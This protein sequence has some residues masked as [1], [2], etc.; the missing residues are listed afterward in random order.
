MRKE[1]AYQII[2]Q[3][4]LIIGKESRTILNAIIENNINSL[5]LPNGINLA[6]INNLALLYKNKLAELSSSHP[7][8]RYLPF[9]HIIKD[10]IPSFDWHLH[11]NSPRINNLRP[12]LLS[13]LLGKVNPDND[14]LLNRKYHHI[15]N[16]P[17][18]IIHKLDH[19][20]KQ[21]N[22]YYPPANE[23]E[24]IINWLWDGLNGKTL[25]V[26]SPICPDYETEPTGNSRCPVRYT[27]KSLG[28]GLGI[29]AQWIAEELPHFMDFLNECNIKINIIVAMADF[30]GFSSENLDR[31]Q[32][33]QK[34]FFVRL[35]SSMQAFAKACSKNVNVVF[36]TDLCGKDKWDLIYHD[37]KN[38]LLNRNYGLSSLNNKILLEIT[39]NRK[40]LYKLWYGE[41]SS[42]EEYNEV[43]LSQGVFYA[44][45]GKI[46]NESFENSLVFAAD[47]RVMRY[48]YNISAE[49][50]TFYLNRNYC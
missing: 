4:K 32:T 36:F 28:S 33:S 40:A 12:S 20:M 10:K 8:P 16:L 9:Y 13:L 34:E 2:K 5:S 21:S 19:F 50:P 31:F 3:N 47:N 38:Q 48:F 44:T 17:V 7:I 45:M 11:I 39:E 6:E 29:I 37:M 1:A 15:N 35:H 26:F 41:R 24:K 14:C 43:T 42:I 25:T 30:E 46:L 18:S 49:L 23:M 27:F 22:M